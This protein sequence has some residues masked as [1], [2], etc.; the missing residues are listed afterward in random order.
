MWERNNKMRQNWSGNT[1]ALVWAKRDQILS[2]TVEKIQSNF[3]DYNEI[4]LL[5]GE[6]QPLTEM[7]G[8]SLLPFPRKYCTTFGTL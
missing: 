6:N 1:A 5:Q 3:V 8:T 4:V 2:L 7:K